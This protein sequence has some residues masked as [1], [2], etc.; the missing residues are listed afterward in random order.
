MDRII[1]IGSESEMVKVSGGLDMLRALR[2]ELHEKKEIA[3]SGYVDTLYNAIQET[4]SN[5]QLLSKE[6]I[7]EL[8]QDELDTLENLVIF[9]DDIK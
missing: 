6:D 5:L 2:R 4:I 7:S 9:I 3:N 8:T 1:T